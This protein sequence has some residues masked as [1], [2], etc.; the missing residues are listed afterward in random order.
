MFGIG[1]KRDKDK[2]Q[3]LLQ[4]RLTVLYKIAYSYFK[5]TDAASDAVQDTALIAYSN[6]NKLKEIEKFNSWIT[7]ILI[8]RCRE[9]LRKNKKIRFEEINDNVI[10]IS[11]NFCGKNSS[12]YEIVEDNLDVLDVLNKIDDK[13]R[14]VIRLKYLGDY[15]LNEIS[16]ILEIPLGTVKS[17]LNT[18]IRSLKKLMEVKDDV[19]QRSERDTL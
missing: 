15:T 17:R 7:T 2:F 9:I 3:Q 19:V 6:I 4:Q 14:E 5:D 13:Y 12:D 18:G 8:N 10:N 11:G 1:D 16:I